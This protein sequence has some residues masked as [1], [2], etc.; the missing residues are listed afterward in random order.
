M[1]GLMVAGRVHW[2]Y[3][4]GSMSTATEAPKHTPFHALHL[5]HKAKMVEFAGYDMP[6]A[7]GSII[8]EHKWCRSSAGFFDVSHMGRLRFSGRHARKFL[9]HVCTRQIYG[10]Q[11]G[12][13]RYSLV[14]NDQGGC[15]DDVLVYCVDEDEYLM[16][17]NASNRHKLLKHFA[18]RKGEFS[19]K[20]ADETDSTAMVAIQGPKAMDLI[21]RISSTIPT[22]KRYNFMV[23][24]LVVIKLL[25]S[26]TGYTGEDGVEVILPSAMAKLAL[27]MVLKDMG[28]DS[29]VVKPVGLGARD[30]LRMEAGMP[31]YGHEITEEIDPVSAGLEFAIKFEKGMTGTDADERT[32]KFI[33]QDALRAIMA[34]GPKLRRVGLF[35]EGR[36]SPRQ[37]MPVLSGGQ[38]VGELTS[39]CISPSLDRGIA[40]AYVPAAMAA[41]GTAFEVD[42]S[43]KGMAAAVVTK[44]P[45]LSNT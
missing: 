45:F 16:V 36:R 13:I 12:M 26:R 40:M 42:L 31:L 5:E 21:S 29:S 27:G 22:M 10:M 2:R 38:V 34:A 19:F 1:V 8:E 17:C 15:R 37:G 41:I 23:K 44:L 43:G 9:D 35:V 24:N 39:G 7:Y 33:G 25:V 30:T 28:G 11:A 32:G 6:I 18:E 3:S 20:L 14:C 4:Y